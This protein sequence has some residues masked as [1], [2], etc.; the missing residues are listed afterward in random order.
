MTTRKHEAKIQRLYQPED[1]D[2]PLHAACSRPSENPGW[3]LGNEF[4]LIYRTKERK[5]KNLQMLKNT[6][7]RKCWRIKNKLSIRQHL[8]KEKQSRFWFC[9]P[10]S[11]AAWPAEFSTFILDF[12]HLRH[13]FLFNGQLTSHSSAGKNAERNFSSRCWKPPPH[14]DLDGDQ[15]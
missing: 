5:T 3:K 13:L 2:V 10:S 14:L 7:H 1:P 15:D 9:N 11:D 8:Q 4:P 12:Q 6:A